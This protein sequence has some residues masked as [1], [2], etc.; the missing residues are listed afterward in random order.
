MQS[1]T[2]P[3]NEAHRRWALRQYDVLDLAR[4]ALFD[5]VTSLAA[6]V[7]GADCADLFGRYSRKWFK[8]CVGLEALETARSVSFCAHAILQP[9]VFIVPDTLA[10]PRFADNPLVTGPPNIRFYAGTPL[11]TAEGHGLGT[12]CVIDT[13]P[14]EL[15]EMQKDAL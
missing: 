12:L 1:A 14:R 3:A 13:K 10:A 7:R 6:C 8:A 4:E 2:L 11:F 5:E 9:C 15:S